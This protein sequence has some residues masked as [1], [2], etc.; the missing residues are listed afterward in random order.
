ME[1][2]AES[3]IVHDGAFDG[4]ALLFGVQVNHV[5][6]ERRIVRVQVAHELLHSFLR[7]EHVVLERAVLFL[8]AL[9]GERD[10]DALVQVCQLAHAGFEYV[11]LIF[12]GGEDASVRPES[13]PGAR[14]VGRS[15]FLYCVERFSAF[16]F[17]LVYLSV[18]EHV[19]GH[20]G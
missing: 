18:A 10:G 9:V 20:V 14:D 5:V 12:C 8:H 11:V 15:H 17:L 4:H 6:D 13:L 3:R 2:L 16:V 19:C 7:V 1:V